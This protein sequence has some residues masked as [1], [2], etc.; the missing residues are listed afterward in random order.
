MNKIKLFFTS[1]LKKDATKTVITSL[2][3]ALLGL[4]L[5]FIILLII[6]ARDAAY[7]MTSVLGNY[8][9]FSGANDRLNYF[10]QTLAKT[11]P[12]IAMSLSLFPCLVSVLTC[13]GGL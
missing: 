4:V 8:L 9:I 6:N 1:L 5:G 12:L 2:W 3:C 7:G 10:G 11:A 13:R